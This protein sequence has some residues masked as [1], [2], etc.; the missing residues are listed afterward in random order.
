MK[1]IN[2]EKREAKKERLQKVAEQLEVLKT[3]LAEIVDEYEE[4]HAEPNIT[5]L[6]AESLAA[7]D[8]AIDGI[9]DVL[10]EA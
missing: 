10:E 6:L 2:F 1:T 7:V 9:Q 5:D 8:D 3:E 4:S